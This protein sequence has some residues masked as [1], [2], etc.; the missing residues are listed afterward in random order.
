MTM[1]AGYLPGALCSIQNRGW[2]ASRMVV[3]QVP[4][5]DPARCGLHGS[6]TP[7][8]K[9][10][11]LACIAVTLVAT[12]CSA[13]QTTPT[14]STPPGTSLGHLTTALTCVPG[15]ADIVPTSQKWVRVWT[16]Q[17]LTVRR[18]MFVGAEVVEPEAYKITL[19]FPWATPVV[20]T[21]GTLAPTQLCRLFPPSTLP[22]AVYYF[23]AVRTGSAIVTVPL[24]RSWLRRSRGCQTPVSCSPLSDL[25]LD[26]TVTS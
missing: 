1:V 26:V 24:S 12:A 23:E 18:G 9:S 20:S 3:E 15:R 16:S 14:T 19:G 8:R 13:A 17:S 25:R 4:V 7:V 22:V 6:M 21:T 5:R 10:R 11:W 2:Y